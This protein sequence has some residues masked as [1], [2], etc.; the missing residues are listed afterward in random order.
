MR[1]RSRMIDPA[2]QHTTWLS[3]TMGIRPQR[4]VEREVDDLKTF[5]EPAARTVPRITGKISD[6]SAL[7]NLLTAL[8]AAGQ[9][10]NDTTE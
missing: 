7:R 4:E 9:I 6:G 2:T 1:S 5:G 8:D 3:D 10:Q